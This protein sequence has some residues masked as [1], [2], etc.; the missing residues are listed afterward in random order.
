MR[1]SWSHLFDVWTRDSMHAANFANTRYADCINETTDAN[2][3]LHVNETI[4][5]WANMHTNIPSMHINIPSMHTNI[6]SMLF[7]WPYDYWHTQTTL[8]QGNYGTCD[9]QP[10]T[11]RPERLSLSIP[12]AAPLNHQRDWLPSESFDARCWPFFS[13]QQPTCHYIN[14]VIER[15]NADAKPDSLLSSLNKQVTWAE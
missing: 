4:C 3:W 8:K 13:S 11:T 15:A 6:P 7:I 12:M 9:G 10:F 14:T 2:K 5:A 1:A